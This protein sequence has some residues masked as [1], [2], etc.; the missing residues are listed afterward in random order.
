[1]P[2]PA[3]LIAPFLEENYYHIICKSLN[4]QLLFVNNENKRFFLQRYKF[5]LH[6]FSSTLAYCLL[7]NHVHFIIKMLTISQVIDQLRA[8]AQS[9]TINQRHF[10]DNPVNEQLDILMERQFNSFF[11]SYTKS[12]NNYYKRKG[13]LFQ[14]PFKR[15]YLKDEMQTT[16]AIIYVHANAQKH[17][18]V[19]DFAAYRWSSY[20][21]ILSNHATL[22]SRDEVLSWFGGK[23]GFIQAHKVQSAY[24]Y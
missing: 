11:V 1:M 15:V 17:K 22:L 3:Q 4:N 21:S 24:Y 12:F 20:T 19:N 7:N 6:P 8:S 2:I 9:I 14:N 10:L 16:Q 18:L 23:E 5:Y 13:N